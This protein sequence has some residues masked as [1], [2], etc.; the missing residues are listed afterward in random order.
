MNVL[1]HELTD[2]ICVLKS[3]IAPASAKIEAICNLLPDL[4]A[5][6]PFG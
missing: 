5:L 6:T 4:E 1:N 3:T 2:R